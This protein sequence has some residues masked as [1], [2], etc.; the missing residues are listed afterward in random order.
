M[1]KMWGRR[2]LLLA[3]LRVFRRKTPTQLPRRGS[4]LLSETELG[5][6]SKQRNV[7]VRTALKGPSAW[8]PQR[9]VSGS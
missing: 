8:L 7:P 1:A 6:G 4:H 5:P 2:R 9:D 3:D